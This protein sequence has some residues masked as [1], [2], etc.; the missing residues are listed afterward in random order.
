MTAD[1]SIS[2][3]EAHA[4]YTPE[5]LS[6][7]APKKGPKHIAIIMDGNRR[8]AKQRGLPPM[9]GHWE[10]AEVLIDTVRSAIELG[11]RTLTVY[12]FSTENWGRPEKEI[13]ALMNIFEV[14]L[15]GKRDL[16]VREGIRLD[17]IG[18]LSLLPEKVRDAFEETKKIT[19]KGDKINLV[20]ALNYGGRDE[21]RRAIVKILEEN[22]RQ[23]VTVTEELIAKHLDTQKWGDPELLIR[24]SGQFRLSNFLLWQL[25]YAQLHMSDVLWPD[26]SSQNLFDAVS[27]FIEKS[28]SR[29]KGV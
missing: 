14:Y 21:I 8:W 23:K 13:D 15:I 27:S 24:T 18:D 4:I 3:E 7:I 1:S 2:L 26:F 6:L 9:M 5:Q 12:T 10:G 28:P 16:M 20:V 17:A 19:E 29:G 22:E 11:I 25:S